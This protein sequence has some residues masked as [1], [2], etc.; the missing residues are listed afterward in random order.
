MTFDAREISPGRWRVHKNGLP[1]GDAVYWN[2]FNC[3]RAAGDCQRAYELGMAAMV[4]EVDRVTREIIS[5]HCWC[6]AELVDGKCP[7]GHVPI[8]V[9]AEGVVR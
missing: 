3:N 9:L 5:R 6:D 7:V 2:E 1:F 8:A 4:K